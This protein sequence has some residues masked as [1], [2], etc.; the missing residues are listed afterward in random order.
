MHRSG[1]PAVRFGAL[2]EKLSGHLPSQVSTRTRGEVA[3]PAR[4]PGDNAHGQTVRSSPS[5]SISSV[6]LKWPGFQYICTPR[7]EGPASG[8][9]LGIPGVYWFEVGIEIA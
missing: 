5:P 4:A 1:G 3:A 9:E 7:E 2:R 6:V 8:I